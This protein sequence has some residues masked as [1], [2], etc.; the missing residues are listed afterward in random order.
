MRRVLAVVALCALPISILSVGL[1]G[2]ASAATP[3]VTANVSCK[4]LKANI[5]GGNGTITKC[6]D[7][8]NTGTKG[9]FPVAALTS[10]SGTIT[11]NGTGTTAVTVTATA[12]PT[13]TACTAVAGTVEYDVTGTTGASTGAA[14]KS[15]PK[16][17]KLAAT[18]CVNTTTGAVTLA[19]GTDFTIT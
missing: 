15:I 8:A 7:K 3:K 1:A 17:S 10:G 2:T 18:A 13:G 6:S 16:K 12:N 11:W 4:A 19:P 9:T 5:S 14:K